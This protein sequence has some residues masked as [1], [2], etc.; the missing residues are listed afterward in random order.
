MMAEMADRAVRTSS[1][2][3]GGTKRAPAWAGRPRSVSA[4]RHILEV[5]TRILQE[6]GYPGLNIERVAQVSGI[7]KTTIYRRY[8]NRQD[9]AAAAVG[10]LLEAHGAFHASDTGSARADLG[11]A[12]AAVWP[13]GASSPVMSVLGAVLSEGKTETGLLERLWARAFGPHHGALAAILQRGIERGEVRSDL[14]VPTTV[15][16][17]VGAVLARLIAGHP[18]SEDWIEAAIATIWQG[19]RSDATGRPGQ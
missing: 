19:I 2:S 3:G 8:E 13:A 18:A 5:A 6:D 11:L 10:A 17:L 14:D 7:A 9:L 4:D 12:Y 1:L 15:E 16:V